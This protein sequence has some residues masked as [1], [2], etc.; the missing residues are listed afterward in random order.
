MLLGG[1][2]A[3]RESDL[4]RIL[5]FGTVSQLGLLTVVLG[6]GTQDAA[7]AGLALLISHA[8]FK[9]A[10]FLVVGVIDRQLSTRDIG[11]LSGVGR[12]APVMATFS[13]IAVASMVGVIPTIGFVAKEGLLTAFLHEAEGGAVWGIVASRRDRPRVG[14]HRGIRH[15]VRLGC[16]L[17]EEVGRGCGRTHGMAR[18]AA[19]VPRRTRSAVGSHDRRRLRRAAS[20]R[21]PRP[22][23][24]AR[25]G[26]DA[27]GRGP[28]EPR[29]SRAV[30]RVRT[31]TVD[32][33]RHDRRR[34]G[35]LLA[36]D[37]EGLDASD[38]ALHGGRRLQ[39]RTARDRAPFGGHD[40]LHPARLAAGVRR[41]DLRRVRRRRGH[42]AAGRQ[43]V[44]GAAGRLPDAHAARR[45]ADHDRGG[46]G[47]GARAEALHGRRARLGH[48]PGDGAAVRDERR[49]RPGAHADPRR[50][51]DP[52][53]VRARP[54]P[55]PVA[56]GRAQCLGVARRARRAGS[57]GR[58][59]DGLRGDRR[60]RGAVGQAD[61]GV[62]S[63]TSPTSSATARTW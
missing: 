50:D 29:T 21:R 2:Q 6:Y 22:V 4:K 37:V 31:R 23:R 57:G 35:P 45:R 46:P 33:T 36:H 61:L 17:D 3:L 63:P 30:A 41:H 25:A 62:D 18:P 12:Q 52:G 10:L 26:I 56:D 27:R 19:R 9:S 16:V 51:G 28:R 34:G 44:A 20:G 32:L 58:R 49:T 13:I 43:R 7:L 5:A 53:R 55:H 38:A 8:L 14:A 48:G 15:P 60:D 54:A 59:D 24:R 39:R 42:G 1:L 11:E 47:R 40:E